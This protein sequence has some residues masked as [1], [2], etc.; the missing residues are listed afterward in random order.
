MDGWMDGWMDE[1]MGRSQDDP[2]S[3]NLEILNMTLRDEAVE[4][5]TLSK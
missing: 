3:R 5:K 2:G 4:I 1:L